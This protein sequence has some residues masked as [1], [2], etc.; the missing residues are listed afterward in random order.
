L[1]PLPNREKVYSIKRL[2]DSAGARERVAH[3]TGRSGG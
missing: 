2:R 3:R 1:R